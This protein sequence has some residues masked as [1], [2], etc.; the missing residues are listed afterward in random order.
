MKSINSRLGILL[1][2]VLALSGCASAPPDEEAGLNQQQVY[3]PI[4][5]F[6]R[7]M[8]T[9]NYDYL[10]PY[11]VRPVSL[12]YVNYV[13]VPI[14]S[15]IS[16]FLGNLDEPSSMINN[17]LMGNG[18]KAL[19]HFN[20]FWINTTFGLAGLIDIASEAGITDHNEKAFSDAVGHYGVGNGPYVMVPGYGPWTVREATDVVDGMYV[21][22]SFLNIWAGLGKWALEGMETRAALVNQEAL[23][24]N[25]PDPYALTRDV[26]IQRQDFKAEIVTEDYDEDEE[27]YLDEYLEEF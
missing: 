20:R 4:E 8:W 25:S 27:A 13:P 14:R 17:L 12:A 16:N 23:L 19:D 18:S 6:N 21:P 24:D 1:V 5:G 2:A 9:I 7:S 11:F 15:G 26:Y 3:D 22:L 10:D